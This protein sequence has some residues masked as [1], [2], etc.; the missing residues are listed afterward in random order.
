MNIVQICPFFEPH[1]GGVETHVAVVSKQL[2]EL[3]HR[4]TVVTLSHDSALPA[5]QVVAGVE[6]IRI[7]KPKAMLSSWSYKV[8]VWSWWWRHRQL[9]VS[10]D[11]VQV[12]DAFWWI[13]P[14]WPLIWSKVFTTFH[15]W[16]GQYPVK[17]SAKIQRWVY[18][19][20]SQATIHVGDWISEFYWD[21]PNLITYGGVDTTEQ[22]QLQT[23]PAKSKKIK[24]VFFGRL[25]STND[26][27]LYLKL[28]AWLKSHL[29]HKKPAQKIEVTWVGEGE[30]RFECE[31]SGLVTGYQPNS[32][33][34]L[35]SADVV[36]ASSYL[37]LW[38]A[39]AV[40]KPVV[41][42]YSHHL[43]KR[44]LET[45]PG[46]SLLLMGNKVEKVGAKLLYLLKDEA[47]LRQ[48]KQKSQRL[49]AAHSWHQVTNIYLKLWSSK[50]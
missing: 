45:F 37:S 18:A 8:A 11:I 16:E 36:L 26:I 13:L 49:A 48:R 29:E 47:Q 50:N 27:A 17:V 31:K 43:K 46:K 22:L 21:R 23:A 12:H 38:Q 32:R 4:V 14:V 25:S 28:V 15:G 5:Q 3:G 20:W 33:E 19:H 6:V 41:A 40:G 7:P 2:Q 10:A 24:L 42:L 34:W 39:L 1:V 30:W 44:Y 9:L 35:Q